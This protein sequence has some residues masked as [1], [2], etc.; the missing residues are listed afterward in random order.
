METRLLGIYLNDHLL[1]ATVG[2]ELARR[3]ARANRANE[4]GR[5]LD[6]LVP[7]L[8]QDRQALLSLCGRV[9]VTPSTVKMTLGRVAERLGRLKPNGRMISY[10][11]LSR[12]L[13]LEGLASGI[14]GKRAL[15]LAL[16]EISA[17]VPGLEH[18]ELEALAARA[19]DQRRRLEPHRL[20]AAQVALTT[21]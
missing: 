13:E 19:A 9:G 18:A 7:E 3:A 10:S 17:S 1:G 20:R 2:V 15:W 6:E 5:F 21:H 11:P 8:V 16:G 14:E 4:W 12:L